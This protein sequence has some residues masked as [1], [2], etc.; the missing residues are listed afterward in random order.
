MG[1]TENRAEK[2]NALN[3]GA[4]IDVIYDINDKIGIIG[5]IEYKRVKALDK[6]K[7]TN[8]VLETDQ[9]ELKFGVQFL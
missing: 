9:I 1:T 3:Y 6:T 4:G 8:F 7:Y 5:G 2:V